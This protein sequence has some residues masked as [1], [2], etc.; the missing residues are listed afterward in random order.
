MLTYSVVGVVR[1]DPVSEV[2]Q[3]A[4]GRKGRTKDWTARSM[5]SLARQSS[6]LKINKNKNV[7]E[8][9]VYII[10]H[11]NEI[12]QLRACPSILVQL[13]LSPTYD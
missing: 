4:G 10:H 12:M 2:V 8:R 9:I 11:P 3:W 13:Y 7:P 1:M 6:E 5:L